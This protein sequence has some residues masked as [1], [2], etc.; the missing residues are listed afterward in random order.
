MADLDEF[1]KEE[2]ADAE[3][4]IKCASSA[5]DSFSKCTFITLA[6]EELN[7]AHMLIR[8]KDNKHEL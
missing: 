4:Y 6:R 8:L 1:I 5:P 7:H 2:F 3:K